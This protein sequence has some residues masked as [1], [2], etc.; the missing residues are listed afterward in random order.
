[1]ETVK[2]P[3]QEMTVMRFFWAKINGRRPQL[4]KIKEPKLLVNSNFVKGTIHYIQQ[5]SKTHLL[6]K[7][8][9]VFVI[10]FV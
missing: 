9:T 3:P 2:L 1:M 6:L 4:D 7:H 5:P 8:S 10:F